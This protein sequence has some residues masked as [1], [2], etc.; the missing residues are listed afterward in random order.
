MLTKK[1]ELAN[2][3]SLGLIACELRL[4]V[5]YMV[6]VHINYKM[7]LWLLTLLYDQYHST[8]NP[9]WRFVYGFL[10]YLLIRVIKGQSIYSIW[11]NSIKGSSQNVTVFFKRR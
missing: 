4:P 7:Y 11:L 2:D 5:L 3:Q 8:S 9:H 1:K 10:L 6:I